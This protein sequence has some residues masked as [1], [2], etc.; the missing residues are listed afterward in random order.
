MADKLIA[1]EPNELLGNT[2][3][4]DTS[5]ISV[6]ASLID[7]VIGQEESVEVIK[8]AAH[9]RR[10]VMLIGSPGT[11]KSMLGKAMAELLPVEELQD[12]LIYPNPEDNN[13]PRV[14]VVPAGRGKQIVDAQKMEARKK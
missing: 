11:G 7:Q 9:Q 6:P 4:Q 1:E 13:T 14:R 10:H 2:D 5:G 12:V 8:K 3:I